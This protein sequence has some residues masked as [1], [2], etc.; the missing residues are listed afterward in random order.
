MLILI[1]FAFIGGII[2]VLSPC[3]LPLLPIILSSTAARG[4]KRPFGI[5]AGFVL[6]FSFFTLF[7]STIVQATG[8]PADSL[9]NISVIILIVFGLTLLIPQIQAQIEKLFSYL[10]R[11]TPNSQNRT[12]FGGGLIIGASLGLLWTPCVGPILASVISLAITGEVTGSALFITLAYSLGTAIPMFLIIRGGQGALQKVPWLVKNSGKI[13]KAFGILMILT[14]L[15]IYLNVDRRF[16]TWFLRTFPS[17]GTGLTAIEDNEFVRNALDAAG[18][19]SSDNDM[20]G[21]PMNEIL[22]DAT[23]NYPEAPEIIPGGE[24]FNSAPLTINFLRG[25]VV[26]IDFWTYSC[27][28]C[29]RTFPYLRSW[30]E[31]YKDDGLVIIGVHTPEFEFEKKAENLKQAI[32]DFE[33]TYPIVQDNN[34]STWRAYNNR[35]WPAKYLIDKE[36]R[37]RYT[38]FGEGAYDETESEIQKLLGE[39]GTTVD[40]PIDNPDYVIESRTPEIY[41]GAKRYNGTGYVRFTGDWELTSEY[42]ESSAGATITLDFYSKDTFIVMRSDQPTRVKTYLDGK[43]LESLTIN[44]DK[45]YELVRLE[46]PGAHSLKLEFLDSGTQAFAF[47]FG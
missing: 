46:E 24:W 39:M 23:T 38:H 28:N 34:Y 15:A 12:G 10:S 36:G 31:K 45:L 21:K 47:T 13:Q 40:E 3:I 37:I 25:K 5:V 20:F 42:A 41:L 19:N 8:I 9:R 43:E 2:T 32:T 35:F 27:I 1:L 30:W 26:L 4:K 6:S 22:N 16:Q 18:N 44:R 29:Q 7:L 14:A 33:L 11:F 17:Y